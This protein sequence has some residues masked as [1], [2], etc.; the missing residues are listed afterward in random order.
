MESTLK[1]LLLL[2]GILY[3]CLNGYTQS[4]VK[5]K[6]QIDLYEGG[7]FGYIGLTLFSD[8]TFRYMERSDIMGIGHRES[9]YFFRTDSSIT[10]I[11]VPR[12]AWLRRWDKR[13]SAEIFRLLPDRIQMYTPEQEQSEN[14]NMYRDYYTLM[15]QRQ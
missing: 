14:G 8:S 13:R 10:L 11:T 1:R 6:Q 7:H 5:A 12:F 15:R 3:C 2:P 4:P 9:G